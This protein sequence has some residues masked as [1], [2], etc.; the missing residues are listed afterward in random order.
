[1]QWIRKR[2]G[3]HDNGADDPQSV[4]YASIAHASWTWPM[5]LNLSMG[6]KIF[7]HLLSAFCFLYLHSTLFCFMYYASVTSVLCL[8]IQY[9]ISPFVLFL[10]FTLV[11]LPTVSPSS[12]HSFLILKFMIHCMNEISTQIRYCYEY[13]VSIRYLDISGSGAK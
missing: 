1:V 9:A 7:L 2:V 6:S 3:H 10:L 11:P 12:F 4:R 8:S 13:H 5:E